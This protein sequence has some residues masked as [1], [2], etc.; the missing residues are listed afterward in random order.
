LNH[1]QRGF[2]YNL[3]VEDQELR[4]TLSIRSANEM[5]AAEVWLER[6]H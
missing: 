1:G 2:L 6:A 5:R 3:K 4:G